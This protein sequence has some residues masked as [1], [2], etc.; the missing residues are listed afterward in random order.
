[1][2]VGDLYMYG[3]AVVVITNVEPMWRNWIPVLSLSTGFSFQVQSHELR[4]I[5]QPDKKCP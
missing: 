5:E 2:K 1:M 4:P 3:N